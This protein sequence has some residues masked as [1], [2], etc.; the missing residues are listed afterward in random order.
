MLCIL[1]ICC[2]PRHKRSAS[3]AQ[4]PQCRKKRK[5][6]LGRQPVNTKLGAK[7]IHTVRTRGGNAKYRALRL[8][9]GNFA[10][11]SETPLV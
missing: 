11:T 6:E 8:D 2:S 1:G 9:H 7:C 10:W 4:R 3:G 5:F